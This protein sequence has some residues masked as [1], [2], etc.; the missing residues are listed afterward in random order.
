M[1]PSFN[2]DGGT[3]KYL[4][5]L[6]DM[7]TREREE[8]GLRITSLETVNTVI[9][10]NEVRIINITTSLVSVGVSRLPLGFTPRSTSWLE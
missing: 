3:F 9:K 5:I 10:S 4:F 8:T 2:I 7:A 6:E 1:T